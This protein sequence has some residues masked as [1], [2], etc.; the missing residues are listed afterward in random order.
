MIVA[1]KEPNA[2]GKQPDAPK[3][4]GRVSIPTRRG[5]PEG[6]GPGPNHGSTPAKIGR[7]PAPRSQESQSKE[8]LCCGEG[9]KKQWSAAVSGGVK[10]IRIATAAQRGQH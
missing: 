2:E 8:E 1:G 5:T 10:P 7:A 4:P 3:Q 9:R 6:Q